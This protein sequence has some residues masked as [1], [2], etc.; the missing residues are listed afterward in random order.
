MWIIR[1]LLPTPCQL[2]PITNLRTLQGKGKVLLLDKDPVPS[3]DDVLPVPRRN[4]FFRFHP[5]LLAAILNGE[6]A[7]WNNNENTEATPPRDPGPFEFRKMLIVNHKA[8]AK[9][10]GRRDVDCDIVCRI[11]CGI[12]QVNSDGVELGHI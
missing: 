11:G 10:L 3:A 4:S 9:L 12:G 8:L 2:K 5:K 7:E 1:L 6:P